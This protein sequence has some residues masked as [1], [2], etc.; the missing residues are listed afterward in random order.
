MSVL[1][2]ISQ[3]MQH[4]QYQGHNQDNVNEIAGNVKCEKS[5]QPKNN[6]NCGDYSKHVF[7]PLFLSA[8]TSAISSR[9]AP[10]PL[11]VQQN[12]AQTPH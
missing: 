1:N 8:R 9:S 5:K 3:E 12:T 10:M 2:A 6:Q 11:R 7:I 4:N